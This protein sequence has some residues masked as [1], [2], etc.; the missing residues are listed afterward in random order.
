LIGLLL[1]VA[2]RLRSNSSGQALMTF[3]PYGPFLIAGAFIML[4][5]G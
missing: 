3:I 2:F 4:F 5:L 1:F